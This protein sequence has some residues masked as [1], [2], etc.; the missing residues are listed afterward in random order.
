[1]TN[2]CSIEECEREAKA[3]GWCKAHWVRWKRH[4][5]PSG[6]GPSHGI[7]MAFIK[8]AIDLALPYECI[9]WPFAHAGNGYGKVFFGGKWTFA[10]RVACTLAHGEPPSPKHQASHLC[11]K[12]HLG[13]M[14]PLHLVWKTPK[15]NNADKIR[16]GTNN[17]GSRNGMSRLTT[18]EV[19]RIRTMIGHATARDIGKLFGVSPQAIYDIQRGRRW[20]AIN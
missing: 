9:H 2:Y 1:M 10:H 19:R 17:A 18:E 13:C 3:R 7:P 6:G 4:G 14:N 11:G 5:D 8:Q 16:H 20:A 15:E 12:G